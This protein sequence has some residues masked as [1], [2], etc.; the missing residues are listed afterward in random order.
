MAKRFDPYPVSQYP[1]GLLNLMRAY[2]VHGSFLAAANGYKPRLTPLQI[3][4]L[5]KLY[6]DAADAWARLATWKKTRWS[7]CALSTY[8]NP[9]TMTGKK[10]MSGYS[11][12][13]KCWI[14]QKPAADHQ[15]ISPCSARMTDPG[16]S[17]W[18]YQP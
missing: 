3:K 15:P 14:E 2:F 13:T 16:A 1:K 17:P 8:G 11:L 5:V 4:A 10:G 18:N 9:D 12:Y 6:T 7:I